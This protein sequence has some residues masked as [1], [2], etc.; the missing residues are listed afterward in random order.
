MT[1][2]DGAEFEEALCFRRAFHYHPL[3]REV[4]GRRF[5]LHVHEVPEDAWGAP[6]VGEPMFGVWPTWHE[7]LTHAASV[8]ARRWEGVPVDG[9]W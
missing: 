4:G 3:Y 5:A 8:Y 6:G 7:A 1:Y 2:K 9:E